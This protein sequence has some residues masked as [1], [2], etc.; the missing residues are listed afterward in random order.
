MCLEL[1]YIKTLY[2]GAGRYKTCKQKGTQMDFSENLISVS[3]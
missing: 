3:Y 1:A 2:G